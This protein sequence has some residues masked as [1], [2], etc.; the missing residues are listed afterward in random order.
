MSTDALLACLRAIRPPADVEEWL[1]FDPPA[2]PPT[3]AVA[4][5]DYR[6]AVRDVLIT[7][8]VLSEETGEVTSP[9][10]YYFVQSLLQTARDGAL[11]ADSWKGLMAEDCAGSGARIVHLLEETRLTCSANPTPLRVIRAVMAVIKAR[12][13]GEDVYLMQYD[14]RAEQFQPIG[15]KQEVTDAS[16]EAALTRELCE[17]LS[18]ASLTPGQDFRI[19]PLVEHVQFKEISASVH[20]VTQYDHGFYHLTDVRFPL[21]TDHTTRWISAAELVARRT[22]DGLAVSPLMDRYM[23]GVLATLPYSVPTPVA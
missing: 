22:G 5:H 12:R 21:N 2:D 17:E 13:G 4:S 10:A 16:S 9:M 3:E 20:V 18:L 8:G 1:R 15:G 19:R 7:L 23:P 11:T 6:R 14:D